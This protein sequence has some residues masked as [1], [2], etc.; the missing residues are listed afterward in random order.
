[1][2]SSEIG[3]LNLYTNAARRGPPQTPR[4]LLGVCVFSFFFPLKTSSLVYT[5]PLFWPIEA[6]EFA[7]LKTPLVYT[8]VPPT[9]CRDSESKIA[10]RQFLPL[11]CRV[12]SI[13]TGAIF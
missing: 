9:K 12:I 2:A 6:L 7:E 10:A 11:S 1:M 13:T 8:F 3:G 4:R 5:K